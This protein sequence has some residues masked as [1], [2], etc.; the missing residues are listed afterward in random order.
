MILVRLV[1]VQRL[2]K[3][4]RSYL[5]GVVLVESHRTDTE[6]VTHQVRRHL[7]V[8]AEMRRCVPERSQ[9]TETGSQPRYGRSRLRRS[10]V[11]QPSYSCY[12][13]LCL[14]LLMV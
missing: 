6:S 2:L 1:A 13:T 8:I 12:R 4:I 7:L 9:P 14:M 11:S 3:M 5:I 10:L